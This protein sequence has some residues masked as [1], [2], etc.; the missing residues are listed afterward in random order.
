MRPT[1]SKSLPVALLVALSLG[2]CS[3]FDPCH[4]VGSDYCDGKK[5]MSCY[6]EDTMFGNTVRLDVDQ[7]C[8]GDSTCV[9]WRA[10]GSDNTKADCFN[11]ESCSGNQSFCLGNA[12]ATCGADGKLED[13]NECGDDV[14]EGNVCVE[15]GNTALCAF[16]DDLRCTPEGSKRCGTN[17]IHICAGGF[18]S[19]MEPCPYGQECITTPEGKPE[20]LL[21]SRSLP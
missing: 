2:A 19:E 1:F 15:S 3:V 13:I 17:E 21:R 18:W 20:C 11:P 8:T 7:T 14:F 4:K 9:Q 10:V 5:V 6:S 16:G 12:L